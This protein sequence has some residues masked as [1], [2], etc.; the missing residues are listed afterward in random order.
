ML[1]HMNAYVIVAETPQ[2]WISAVVFAPDAE[3]ALELFLKGKDVMEMRQVRFAPLPEL[4]GV[5]IGD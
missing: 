4:W 3:L 2:G 1:S 5:E